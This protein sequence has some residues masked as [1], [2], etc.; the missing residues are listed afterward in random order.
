MLSVPARQEKCN[1]FVNACL[2]A[3]A[4][5]QSISRQSEDGR[6][7][8]KPYLPCDMSVLLYGCETW[9]RTPFKTM[10]A[11][12][13]PCMWQQTSMT[14]IMW[15]DSTINHLRRTITEVQHKIKHHIK[16]SLATKMRFF[17]DC[18]HVNEAIDGELNKARP[19]RNTHS[20][21]YSHMRA[22]SFN[23]GDLFQSSILL[24]TLKGPDSFNN[25]FHLY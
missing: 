16:E 10:T 11:R 7:V 25:P 3:S 13:L 15:V 6:F 14:Q 8:L 4:S 18:Y 12:I 5:A 2:N 24:S 21:P 1:A 20:F 9:Q 23:M 19:H 17:L 22:Y